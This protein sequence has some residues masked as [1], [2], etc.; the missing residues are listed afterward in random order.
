MERRRPILS[1]D[2]VYKPRKI[3]GLHIQEIEASSLAF[4]CKLAWKILQDNPNLRTAVIKQKYLWKIEF[5]EYDPKANNSLVWKSTLRKRV[6][7]NK[8]IGW[9]L[10]N[11]ECIRFWWDDYQPI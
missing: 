2:K 1:W 8:G 4:Q 6:V 3:G 11:G 7:L 10:E 9:K 5:L